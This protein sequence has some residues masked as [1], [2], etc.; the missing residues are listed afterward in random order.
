[1]ALP[2]LT[3]TQTADQSMYKG[4]MG[5]AICAGSDCKVEEGQADWQLGTSR[6]TSRNGVL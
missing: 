6:R 4:I 2:T 5:T 1:M 3:V